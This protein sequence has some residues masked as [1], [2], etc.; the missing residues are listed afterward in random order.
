MDIISYSAASAWVLFL[1]VLP[2]H[3]YYFFQCSQGLGIISYS[4]ASAW[5]IYLTVL[6]GHGYYFLQCCQRLGNIFDSAASA[7]VLFLTVL[8]GH[9]YYFG[10]SVRRSDGLINYRNLHYRLC[11]GSNTTYTAPPPARL[12]TKHRIVHFCFTKQTAPLKKVRSQK[13]FGKGYGGPF[14]VLLSNKTV[15]LGSNTVM[16]GRV[17]VL[18]VTYHGRKGNIPRRQT[19]CSP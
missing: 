19:K 1:T 12:Y 3:G 16:T 5:V 15:V 13:R 9:G 8:P 18:T 14:V 17:T 6:P 4:A 10:I 7:W 2:G 11:G